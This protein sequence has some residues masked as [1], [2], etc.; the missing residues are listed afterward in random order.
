L[1][2]DATVWRVHRKLIEP[3]FNSGIIKLFLT[4]FHEKTMICME[5]LDSLSGG[6]EFNIFEFWGRLT[7]DNLL[8]T[9]FGTNKNVQDNAEDQTLKLVNR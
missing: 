7:L 1:F 3:A 4:V 6:A 2:D 5:K 9:S 8:S